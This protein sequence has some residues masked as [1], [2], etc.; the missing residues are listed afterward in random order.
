MDLPPTRTPLIRWQLANAAFGVPQAAGPIAFALLTIPLTGDP[1]SGA[2]IVLT[3][4]IAQVVG[5][6]PIARLGRNRNAVAFLKL[7]VGIRMLAL[8]AITLLAAVGAPFALL[9]VAAGLAGLVNG[10]AFGALRSVLNHLVAPSGMPRALGIAATLSEFTFVASPVLASMLGSLDP[11]LALLALSLLGSTPMLLMPRIPHARA[12]APPGGGGRLLQPAILLWMACTMANSAVVSS[13]EVG[14]VSLAVEYGFPPAMGFIF[15]VALCLASVAGGVWVSVRN[16]VPGRATVLA[17]LALMSTGAALIAAH[18]PVAA[19]LAGAV[20]VGCCMAPLS[21]YYSL[22]LDALAPP[23][24]KA[25]I[26]ALSRTAN[27][28]GIILTSANLA[29]TSLAVTQATSAGLILAATAAVAIL[30]RPG[31]QDRPAG[32][33]NG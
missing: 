18:L 3:M 33:L 27:A 23:H 16:R 22:R 20:I 4:T 9:L 21:T 25:E 28:L 14:A 31:R 19:T 29:L 6:V 26:F 2:A 24:R 11:V 10:A 5:A 13:V 30:A 12:I 1:N 15:T 17:Y 32:P 8:A 7:L